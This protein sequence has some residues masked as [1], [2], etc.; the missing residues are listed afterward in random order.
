MVPT[1]TA[2]LSQNQNF[3]S[4]SPTTLARVP[5]SR[6]A[7]GLVRVAFLVRHHKPL[8]EGPAPLTALLFWGP[9]WGGRLFTQS[10][11]RCPVR[12]MNFRYTP[13]C[14]SLGRSHHGSSCWSASITPTSIVTP[15]FAWQSIG[16]RA[17]REV[18][19]MAKCTGPKVFLWGGGVCI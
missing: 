7:L 2:V 6:S 16:V 3:S 14:P 10:M 15:L 19:M 9:G 13:P 18:A 8:R 12:P 17:P 5:P 4:P 1:A 11:K